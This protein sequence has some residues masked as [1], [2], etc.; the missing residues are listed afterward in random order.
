MKTIILS[1][2]LITIVCSSSIIGQVKDN[3]VAAPVELTTSIPLF[4]V[5]GRI[6]HMAY[7]NKQQLI[8]VAELSNNTM[9]VVDIQNKK[10]VHSVKS[11]NQPNGVDFNPNTDMIFVACLGDGLC[12]AFNSNTYKESG[13]Q[14]LGGI[15]NTVIYSRLSQQLYIGYGEGAIAVYDGNAIKIKSTI[16]LPAHPESFQI[17]E[18]SNILFVNI[19]KIRQLVVIDLKSNAIRTTWK[20]EEAAENYPMA[21]DTANHRLFIGCRNPAKLLVLDSETGNKITSMDIYGDVNDIFFNNTSK[22]IYVC[23]GDGYLNIIKQD[24]KKIEQVIKQDIKP[25]T[26]NTKSKTGTKQVKQSTK[27]ETRMIKQDTYETISKIFTSA[28]ARTC[29]FIP[30]LNQLI[31]AAPAIS[32]KDAQLMMYQIK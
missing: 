19:P 25:V 4:G 11:L 17:D 28:G 26:R 14:N 15:V 22:Q 31:V 27:Q 12:R 3:N 24:I 8:Y 5:T 7:N 9:Q 6:G 10:V 32:D 2:S 30:E 1:L 18:K 13:S 29:L 20:I 16:K 21:L 23:C